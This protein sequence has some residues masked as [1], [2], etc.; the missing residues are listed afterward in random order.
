MPPKKGSRKGKQNA[1]RA[2]AAAAGR[3]AAATK[4]SSSLLAH[5][6]QLPEPVKEEDRELILTSEKR[7]GVYHCDYCHSD[8]SQLPR[9][10]CKF[11]TS[12]G[13]VCFSLLMLPSF[14]RN[15]EQ[16]NMNGVF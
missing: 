14:Y 6:Q 15:P 10:R 12:V 1:S 5:Q 13:C 7:R 3:S 8:I 4:Q 11:W 2:A 16:S 9:I